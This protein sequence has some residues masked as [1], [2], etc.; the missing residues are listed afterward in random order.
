MTEPASTAAGGF[1]LTKLLFPGL[2]AVLVVVVVMAMTLPQTRRE[3][4]VALIS[5]LAGSLFG[6]AALIQWLGIA[7]WGLTFE[8]QVA[9]GAFYFGGGL[10]A[11]VL[12]RGWFAYAE[13]SKGRSLLDMIRELREAT[14]K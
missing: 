6:G 8:G 9:L 12:V 3:W 7:D 4:V 1:A 13:T 14:G 10:P 11:W 5:T 2:G